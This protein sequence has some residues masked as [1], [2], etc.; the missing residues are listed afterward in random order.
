MFVIETHESKNLLVER[1]SDKTVGDVMEDNQEVS[2]FAG[3]L[4][5]HQDA[6]LHFLLGGSLQIN[7]TCNYQVVIF[8]WPVIGESTL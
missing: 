2:I 4:R 8:L 6:C 5:V 1:F 3:F 7:H